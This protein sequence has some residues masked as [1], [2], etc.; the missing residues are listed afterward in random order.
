MVCCVV[1]TPPQVQLRFAYSFRAERKRKIFSR[2]WKT[3]SE[4]KAPASTRTITAPRRRQ[5]RKTLRK[6]IKI[7][8][9]ISQ[10]RKSR[11]TSIK[12]MAAP[13]PPKRR[14]QDAR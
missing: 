6:H 4:A 1:S 10:K 7:T 9:G 5:N 12:A 11:R 3:P 13:R 8:A 14:I 2:N